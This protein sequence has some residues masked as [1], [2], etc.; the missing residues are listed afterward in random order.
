[1]SGSPFQDQLTW[2]FCVF[3]RN[4]YEKLVQICMGRISGEAVT[5]MRQAASQWAPSP[6]SHTF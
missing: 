5:H 3:G 4:G 2:T 6:G 1:M